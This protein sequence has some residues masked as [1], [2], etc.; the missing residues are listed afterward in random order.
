[1][2]SLSP[3]I[4]PEQ[5]H[6]WFH[7]VQMDVVKAFR[8]LTREPSRCFEVLWPDSDSRGQSQTCKKFGR[9]DDRRRVD[10]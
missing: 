5:L 4:T 10:R 7:A 3:P 2:P 8:L 1:M 6:V 9:D